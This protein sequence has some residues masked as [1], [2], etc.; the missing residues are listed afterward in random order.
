MAKYDFVAHTV[1]YFP[2]TQRDFMADFVSY[3]PLTEQG[4]FPFLIFIFIWRFHLPWL[5]LGSKTLPP[6]YACWVVS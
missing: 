1:S 5:T 4:C 6:V 3:F 2:L